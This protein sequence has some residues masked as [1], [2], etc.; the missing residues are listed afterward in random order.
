MNNGSVATL[1]AFTCVIIDT[2]LN[3]EVHV[4]VNANVT[5]TRTC[6]VHTKGLFTRN[7][8]ICICIKRQEWV[9]WQQV[10]VFKLSTFPFSRTEWQRSKKNAHV[11]MNRNMS[12]NLFVHARRSINHSFKEFH[13]FRLELTRCP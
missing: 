5:R 3:F 1:C 4:D 2:I 6:L 12:D 11:L 10:I 9:L 13:V 7:V 8:C